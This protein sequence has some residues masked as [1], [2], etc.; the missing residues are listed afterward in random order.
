MWLGGWGPGSEADRYMICELEEMGYSSLWFGEAPG[1]REPFTR[2]AT[3][4][5]STDRIR[6]GTGI[7]SIWLRS[8][9]AMGGA[10]ETLGE[11]FPGRFVLGMGV[12]HGPLV[13]DQ[14]FVYQRPRSQMRAYLEAMSKLSYGFD[15]S[16]T[17]VPRVIAALRPRMLELAAESAD[18]AHPY[19]V[20]VE[21]TA[22]ARE[23]LGPD[24][25]LVPEVAVV[26]SDD[27]REARDIARNHV[28]SFYLN[29]ENYVECLRWLG[30]AE[31]DLEHGGSDALVD[32]IVAWGD[33]TSI[34]DRVADHLAAGA[35]EVLIQPIA[36]FEPTAQLEQLRRL[37][38]AL[39]G[40]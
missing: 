30:W 19:F 26:V 28:A 16:R 31:A 25:L 36:S 38:P 35:D 27:R 23:I 7:A 29:A 13:E 22:R 17:P 39:V 2:A 1:G 6:V 4:L 32:A 21:H 33:E 9:A 18:G 14:G 40:I 34:R 10:A 5:A 37:A 3:L 11:A 8:P 20:P 15:R 12:S 24:K